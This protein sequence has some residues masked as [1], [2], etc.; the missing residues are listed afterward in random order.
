MCLWGWVCAPG[1]TKRGGR[2]ILWPNWNR[3]LLPL[4]C[5]EVPEERGFVLV[6]LWWEQLGNGD[7]WGSPE[8]EARGAPGR[9][10]E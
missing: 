2:G 5:P 6:G 7:R 4:S 10:R 3:R 1:W 9:L 8:C